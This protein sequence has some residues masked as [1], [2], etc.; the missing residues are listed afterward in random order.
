MCIYIYINIL[1][2]ELE[3]KFLWGLSLFR[4]MEGANSLMHIPSMNYMNVRP[5]YYI[6]LENILIA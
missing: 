1:I 5:D 6:H 3:T 4:K 2:Q